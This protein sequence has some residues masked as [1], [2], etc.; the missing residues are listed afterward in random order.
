MTPEEPGAEVAGSPATGNG[1]PAPCDPCVEAPQ[2]TDA[3]VVA[4]E[5]GEK[6]EGG[7]GG[8]GGGG[9][10]ATATTVKAVGIDPSEHRMEGQTDLGNGAGNG[11]GSGIRKDVGSDTGNNVGG[12]IENGAGN[13]AGNGAANDSGNGVGHDERKASQAV[14]TS[15]TLPQAGRP[16]RRLSESSVRSATGCD[17][18]WQWNNKIQPTGMIVSQRYRL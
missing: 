14:G 3:T 18:I 5:E 12:T 13:G 2:G 6:E 10:A 8:K 4:V 17:R 1:V 15:E 9:T 16:A 7:R 11:L